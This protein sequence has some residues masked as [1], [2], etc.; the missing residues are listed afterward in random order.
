[1]DGNEEREMSVATV[2]SDIFRKLQAG[3]KNVTTER[4]TEKFVRKGFD[5]LKQQDAQEFLR[6]IM[7]D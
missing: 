3:D 2:L 5:C 4:L 1:M 7:D 6:L